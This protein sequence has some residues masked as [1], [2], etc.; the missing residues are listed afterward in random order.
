MRRFLAVA[1]LAA[2]LGQSVCA[3]GASLPAVVGPESESSVEPMGLVKKYVS[4]EHS[5]SD[6][7]ELAITDDSKIRIRGRTSTGATRFQLI[8]VGATKLLLQGY[9]GFD[10]SFQRVYDATKRQ[11]TGVTRLLLGL[12]DEDRSTFWG[13]YTVTCLSREK[14]ALCF[15]QSPVYEHNLAAFELNAPPGPN[16]YLG[17]D[18]A[19]AEEREAIAKLASD[20][21]V[22]VATDYEKLLRIHDWITDHIY[23]NYDGYRSGNYSGNYGRTDAYGTLQ[24]RM[25]VC[26]GY[27][28][29]TEALLRSVGIPAR[30]VSGHVLDVRA[31]GRYW[32]EV[33]HS[34]IN[35]SWN[36]AFVD[37]RWVILDT[38]WDTRNRYEHGKFKKGPTSYVYFDPSLQAFSYTHKILQR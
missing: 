31:G 9:V 15:V 2:L 26:H 23:Y 32:D 12:Y 25:S 7:L 14:G 3:F 17:I 35:H 13:V 33:D 1:L 21:V 8:D 38:T 34:E 24:S 30:V 20:I 4:S 28:V 11:D 36:E 5:S 16:E 27:A 18:I 6:F 29:L 22:G 19:G 37:G 10:G